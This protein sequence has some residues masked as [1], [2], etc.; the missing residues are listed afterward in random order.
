MPDR[1]NIKIDVSTYDRLSEKKGEFETWDGVLNRMLNEL[2]T[3]E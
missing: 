1:K 2:D 3:D